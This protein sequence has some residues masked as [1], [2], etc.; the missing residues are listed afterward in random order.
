M[1]GT[2]P[3]WPCDPM[4]I[5]FTNQWFRLNCKAIYHLRILTV[6][7]SAVTLCGIYHRVVWVGKSVHLIPQSLL[8]QRTSTD[9]FC[10]MC[11][12]LYLWALV[13]HWWDRLAGTG[14]NLWPVWVSTYSGVASIVILPRQCF[15]W[16][17]DFPLSTDGRSLWIWWQWWSDRAGRKPGHL[18]P[19]WHPEKETHWYAHEISDLQSRWLTVADH[20]TEHS[21]LIWNV[22][23]QY[24]STWVIDQSTRDKPRIIGY[25]SWSLL[26]IA[27]YKH[28]CAVRHRFHS[29]SLSYSL[30]R[31][32]VVCQK[33][34]FIRSCGAEKAVIP[35]SVQ[36]HIRGFIQIK[37]TIIRHI[38][39]FLWTHMR[40]RLSNM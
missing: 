16:F 32:E 40:M 35:N 11:M 6:S 38:F 22:L 12:L 36:L 15:M 25:C 8:Q 26:N 7:L 18:W 17:T 29:C 31:T 21:S 2:I 23:V 39:F 28:S 27:A 5:G 30:L 14:L 19:C 4:R 1:T 37:L 20:W 9:C 33:L 24:M 34:P 3:E 13:V 10:S